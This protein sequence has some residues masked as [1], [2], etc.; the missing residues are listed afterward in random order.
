MDNL[1]FFSP[2]G[3]LMLN[4]KGKGRPRGGDTFFGGENRITQQLLLQ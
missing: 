4:I 2:K 1:F 3:E